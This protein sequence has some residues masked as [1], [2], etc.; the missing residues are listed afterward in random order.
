MRVISKRRL[1]EFWE[2]H[3]NAKAPLTHWYNTT[4]DDEIDWQNHNDVR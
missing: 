4:S 2:E 1:K 3:A